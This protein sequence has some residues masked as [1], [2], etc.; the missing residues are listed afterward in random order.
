MEARRQRVIDLI[1]AQVKPA[2]VARVT[3]V[4]RQAVY[5]IIKGFKATVGGLIVIVEVNKKWLDE[6]LA[7]LANLE[8]TF[9]ADPMV[10]IK[11][12]NKAKN[13][14]KIMIW[15]CIKCLGL[16]TYVRRW[17]QLIIE[18]SEWA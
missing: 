17:L 10:S 14:N 6:F 13:V 16:K 9:E 12:L 18:A 1:H 8:S 7:D 15:G 2:E 11:Q 5:N 4:F 3:G